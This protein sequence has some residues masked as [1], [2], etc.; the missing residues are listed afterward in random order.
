[1]AQQAKLWGWGIAAILAIGMLSWV[2]YLPASTWWNKKDGYIPAVATVVNQTANPVILNELDFWLFSLSH[3][4]R[5]NVHLLVFD[6]RGGIPALPKGYSDYFLFNASES[7]TQL[8]QQQGVQLESI[9]DL[10]GVPFVRIPSQ[11]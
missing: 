5:P 3:S 1:E 7:L 9:P 11:P 4:L 10:E 6:R 2:N 8:M